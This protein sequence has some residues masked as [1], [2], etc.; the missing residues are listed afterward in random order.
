MNSLRAELQNDLRSQ[1]E[2][3]FKIM[4]RQSQS[5]GEAK[6]S[7]LEEKVDSLQQQLLEGRIEYSVLKQRCD[8]LLYH[9][10]SIILQR[11]FDEEAKVVRLEQDIKSLRKSFDE[12][13]RK[14]NYFQLVHKNRNREY[15]HNIPT[16]DELSSLGFNHDN[17]EYTGRA[18]K[19]QVFS[20]DKLKI[21]AKSMRQE[22]ME[23]KNEE[24]LLLSMDEVLGSPDAGKIIVQSNVEY[25]LE[26]K[27]PERMAINDIVTIL[28]TKG[29]V[30]SKDI[31]S[32]CW[33]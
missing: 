22:W 23:V 7:Q 14:A 19:G 5:E 28:F 18:G 11:Q 27:D 33:V 24:E 12:T 2:Q 8:K 26:A 29:R 30:T 25:A 1:Y 17:A 31:K 32:P 10:N 21:R 20:E 6:L 15:L 3:E 4:L 16:M 9:T 13:Q